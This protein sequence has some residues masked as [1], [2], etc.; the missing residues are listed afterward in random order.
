MYTCVYI[1]ITKHETNALYKSFK[2]GFEKV[3]SQIPGIYTYATIGQFFKKFKSLPYFFGRFPLLPAYMSY[4][5][6]LRKGTVV[7]KSVSL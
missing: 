6:S 4:L 2:V 7:I 3:I 5:M 1:T